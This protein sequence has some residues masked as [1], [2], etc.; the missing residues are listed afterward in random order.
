MPHSSKDWKAAIRVSSFISWSWSV[1]QCRFPERPFKETIGN[2]RH[3]EKKNAHVVG[4]NEKDKHEIASKGQTQGQ[5]NLQRLK[6]VLTTFQGLQQVNSSAI[7]KNSGHWLVCPHIHSRCFAFSAWHIQDY[8]SQAL[9]PDYSQVGSDN[10]RHERKT[11]GCARMSYLTSGGISARVS[12]LDSF[13]LLSQL[14]RH[15]LFLYCLIS[16]CT[17]PHWQQCPGVAK[18]WDSSLSH[19]LAPQLFYYLHGQF[20]VL[21]YSA[22]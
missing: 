3:L 16:H 8:F 9:L 1:L 2:H 18:P 12:N 20:P 15:G 22:R 13:L 6:T 19:C 11:G 17:R 4:L 5:R 7:M 14:Q 10:G 21:N